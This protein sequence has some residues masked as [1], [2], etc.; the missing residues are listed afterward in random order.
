MAKCLNGGA[1]VNGKCMCKKGFEGELCE[2]NLN[3]GSNAG[4][5]ILLI[6]IIAAAGVGIYLLVKKNQNSWTKSGAGEASYKSEFIEN[7]QKQTE[8]KN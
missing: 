8:I 1:C 7:N 2:V 5:I 3:E 4:W 6:L